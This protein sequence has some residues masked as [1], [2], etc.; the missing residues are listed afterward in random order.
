MSPKTKRGIFLAVSL[1]LVVTGVV[2]LVNVFS[3]NLVFFYD[4]SELSKGKAP[5]DRAIRVGGLVAMDTVETKEETL[6]FQLTDGAEAVVVTYEGLPP[7]LFRE[8]Q[9]VLVEG[10][11]DGVQVT[12]TRILTKHDENYM[13]PE[14]A[15]SLKQK[16]LWQGQAG[17]PVTPGM[18]RAP[19][20]P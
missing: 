19:E 12:A 3:Q 18:L 8:G 16:G 20:A 9:G 17:E 1:S 5:Q 6:F 7:A 10:H 15:K 4:P 14:I 11:W 13:P 2:M